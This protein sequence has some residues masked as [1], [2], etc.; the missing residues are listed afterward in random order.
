VLV[1]DARMSYFKPP[2]MHRRAIWPWFALATAFLIGV[3]PWLPAPYNGD[4]IILAAELHFQGQ[5]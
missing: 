5:S 1:K 4:T 2:A 3:F